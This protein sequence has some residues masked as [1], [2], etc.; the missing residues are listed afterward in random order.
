MITMYVQRT[1]IAARICTNKFARCK[2]SRAT[3]EGNAITPST[4]FVSY[5]LY[6]LT[7]HQ[8]HQY[9]ILTMSH[10]HTVNSLKESLPHCYTLLLSL[11]TTNL[12]NLEGERDAAHPSPIEGGISYTRTHVVR[13]VNSLFRK[14]RIASRI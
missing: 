2:G 7:I 14:F 4:T 12:E 13:L 10:C 9:T 8:Y 5:R 1:M 6:R 3:A 11:L